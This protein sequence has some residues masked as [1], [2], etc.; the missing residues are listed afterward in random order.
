MD[1][2]GGSQ[3]YIS[4]DDKIWEIMMNLRNHLEYQSFEFW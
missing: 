1:S 2:A 4:D 3:N